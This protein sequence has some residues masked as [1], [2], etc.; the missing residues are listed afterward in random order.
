MIT[1]VMMPRLDGIRLTEE[2]RRL[3]PGLPI[4]VMSGLIEPDQD[5][6]NRKRLRDL[7]VTTFVGKPC[8]ESELL[9]AL[10]RT[11]HAAA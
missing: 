10:D 2:T 11:L 4:I 6:E 3:R 8:S 9:D 5:T 7:G 1:D